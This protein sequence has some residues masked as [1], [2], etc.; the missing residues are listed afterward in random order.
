MKTV[1]IIISPGGEIQI[2]A[3]GFNGPDCERATRYLEEALGVVGNRVKKPEHQQRNRT[4]A[5]QKVGL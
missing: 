2:D 3:V 1:E 4:K 5:Q